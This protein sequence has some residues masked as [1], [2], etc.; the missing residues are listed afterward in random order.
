MPLAGKRQE[1]ED[2]DGRSGNDAYRLKSETSVVIPC[3]NEAARID[4]EKFLSFARENNNIRLVFVDDGSTDATI[5]KLFTAMSALPSQVDVLMMKQNGGKA[6]AVRQGLKFCCERGDKYVAFLDAD[7][8]TPLDAILDFTSVAER[9]PEIDVV[10]GSRCGGMGRRVYRKIY[11]KIISLV[12]A[13]M[14]RLATGLP[15]RDTQCGA[16]LFR[17]TDQFARSLAEPFEAGWLFDVELFLRISEP[18]KS[19]KGK[20]YEFPVVQWTEIP[21]SKIK[22]TDILKSGFKMTELIVKQWKIRRQFRKTGKLPKGEHVQNLRCGQKLAYSDVLALKDIVDPSIECI[23]L[24]LSQVQTLGPSVMT[25]LIELTDQLE[26][27]GHTVE[28]ILPKSGNVLETAIRS[29]LTSVFNC[30]KANGPER[31]VDIRPE[32]YVVEA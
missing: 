17:N 9:I 12:C 6:E 22:P 3:Y 26:R 2:S 29:G 10:F 21:G 11:R 13:F 30:T 27:D 23:S 19:Q 8:A 16:K 20:F 32:L 5:D 1:Y 14:G 25:S 28:M 15:I 24:D 18:G 4:I 7:L 31:K